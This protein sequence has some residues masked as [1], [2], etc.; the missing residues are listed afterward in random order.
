MF[1]SQPHF[2]MGERAVPIKYLDDESKDKAGEMEDLHNPIL[3]P[4]KTTQR[5]KDDPKEMD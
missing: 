3:D 2:E 4:P 1:R 5:E